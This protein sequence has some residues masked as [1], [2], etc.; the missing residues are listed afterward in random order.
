MIR[1]RVSNLDQWV[2]YLEPE[3]EAFEVST[4]EFISQLKREAPANDAMLAGTAFHSLLER[5]KAGAEI[6]DGVEVDGFTFR[7]DTDYDLYIP[8]V[9]EEETPLR[10]FDTPAGPAS[11]QGRTDARDGWTVIDYKLTSRF[12]AERYGKSMQW[13]AYLLLTGARRFRYLAFENKRKERDVVIRD[14]HELD[15]WRYDGMEEEVERRVRELAEFVYAH[16]PELVTEPEMEGVG[17]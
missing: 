17:T 3:I 15:F 14:I 7:F 12:N 4:E 11:L 9:R 16:V 5:V 8:P 13:R 10:V 6:E 2:N 1:L